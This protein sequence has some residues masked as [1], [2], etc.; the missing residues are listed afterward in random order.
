MFGLGESDNT[1]FEITTPIGFCVRVTEG[2]WR[3]ITEIKHP[4]MSDKLLLVEYVLRDPDLIRR[5]KTDSKVFL[6]YLEIGVKRWICNVVKQENG[7]G[8]LI[9]SY[10]TSAIKE[11]ELIWS[12]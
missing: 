9:T 10:V 2:R 11:G 1:L 4:M 5:S 3:E 8:F 12:K 6:F 7:T